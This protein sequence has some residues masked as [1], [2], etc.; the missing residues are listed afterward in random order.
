[1]AL[2]MGICK[3]LYLDNKQVLSHLPFAFYPYALKRAAYEK[4]NQMHYIWHKLFVSVAADREFVAKLAAMFSKGDSFMERHLHMY[5]KQPNPAVGVACARVD[6]MGDSSPQLV[7]YN[8]M[9]VGLNG[10]SD[11]IQK[12]QTA[13]DRYGGSG[14]IY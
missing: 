14:K 9:S 5:M 4:L 13:F 1:M 10:M 8:L 2:V 12:L 3:T 6:Y 11:R 7:E